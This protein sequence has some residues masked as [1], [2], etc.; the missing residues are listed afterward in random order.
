MIARIWYGRTKAEDR[1]EYAAY[2]NE[3]GIK[4]L[5]STPGNL[6]AMILSRLV[7]NEA[8][9]IVLSLWDSMEAIRSFAGDKPEV[10]V[11][12]PEDEA[13]LK[14]LDPQVHHYQVDFIQPDAP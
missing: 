2:M 7:E 13:F 9:F 14:E 6:Q 1:A 8:E 12:F 10:A 4:A 11:Y 5:R 3:T